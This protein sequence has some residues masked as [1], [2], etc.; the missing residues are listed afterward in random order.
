MTCSPGSKEFH[1]DILIVLEKP[2]GG[3]GLHIAV[4]YG[5]YGDC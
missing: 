2:G 1:E 5:G 3:A 4:M